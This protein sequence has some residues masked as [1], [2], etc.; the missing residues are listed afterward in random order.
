MLSLRNVTFGYGGR[1]LLDNI[2]LTLPDTGLFILLGDSGCGKT[3]FL[4]LC[5]DTL[6]PERGTIE[7]KPDVKPARVYQSP[8]LLDY[9]DVLS[10]VRLPLFLEG[11]EGKMAEEK[12]LSA[13]KE[14][15][16]VGFE[17]RDVKSLSGGEKM[18]VSLA[19]ALVTHS[20]YLILDEPTGQLDEKTSREIYTL[21]GKLSKKR[22]ILLVTHDERNAIQMADFLYR[23]EDGKLLS[24]KESKKQ[25]GKAISGENKTGKGHLRLFDAIFLLFS[26]LKKRRLR[27]LLSTFFLGLLLTFLSLGIDLTMNIDSSLDA[28]FSEYYDS[29]VMTLSQ[30]ETIAEGGNLSLERYLV[31]SPETCQQLGIGKTYPSFSYFLPEAETLSYGLLESDVSL[32]PVLKQDR[33]R[34]LL[35]REAQSE[36]EIVANLSFVE[37]FFSSPKEAMGKVFH[38]RHSAVVFSAD[39]QGKDLVQLDF[40]LTIVGIAKEKKAFNVP[41]AYYDYDSLS[42]RL[43]DVYLENISAELG[44]TVSILDLFSETSSREDDFRGNKILFAT[45]D[46]QKM[47]TRGENLFGENIRL[48]SKSGEIQE[49]TST[50]V[51]SL[52]DVLLAFL[53]LDL[54]SI[55]MLSYLSVYSLYE[56]NIRLFALVKTHDNAKRNKRIVSYGMLFSF[57]LPSALFVLALS[58][59]LS[60]LANFLLGLFSFPPFLSPFNILSFLVV[61]LLAFLFSVLASLL[62]LG[63]IKDGAIQKELEG[64]D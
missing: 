53:V 14:V 22:L 10:N 16:L 60:F 59:L 19:R 29:N 34:L 8:L 23:L 5:S 17:N 1:K 43:G 57:F 7:R 6:K 33:N 56:E 32:L 12:A 39:L 9:L 64:Q 55:F 25:D 26:F 51:T 31:P 4:S 63:K 36:N 40:H 58:L 18:R 44:K 61:L 45:D 41:T 11:M 47:M 38:F 62:P 50:I 28:L 48:Y 37:A 24:L 30:M 27:L 13:L 54:M 52:L 35:G 21:L 49:S 46:V 2:T 3:T 20:P 42:S 15:E